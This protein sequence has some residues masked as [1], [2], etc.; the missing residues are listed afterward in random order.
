MNIDTDNWSNDFN[1]QY[2]LI[3]KATAKKRKQ[4]Y[5]KILGLVIL[6]SILGLLSMYPTFYFAVWMLE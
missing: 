6:Y 4:T 1:V 3:K 5:Y 2:Y